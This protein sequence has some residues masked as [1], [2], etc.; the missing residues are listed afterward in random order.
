MA[1][2]R[3]TAKALLRAQHLRQGLKKLSRERVGQETRKLLCGKRAGEVALLM[4]EAG[5]NQDIVWIHDG[6]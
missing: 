2:V 6:P 1:G 4:N 5:I 3:S